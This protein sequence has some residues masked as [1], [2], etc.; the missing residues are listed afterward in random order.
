MGPASS[1]ALLSL[2]QF[3]LDGEVLSLKDLQVSLVGVG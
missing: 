3:L 2:A 1:P